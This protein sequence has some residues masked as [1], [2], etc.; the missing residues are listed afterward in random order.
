LCLTITILII[1]LYL[2]K[3]NIFDKI[4]I[5]TILYKFYFKHIINKKIFNNQILFYILY[6]INVLIISFY[7]K[8][9]L[10]IIIL[11]L[12]LNFFFLDIFFIC[13]FVVS[14]LAYYYFFYFSLYYF[15]LQLLITMIINN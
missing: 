6:V 14:L 12:L 5:L 2:I 8:Y 9:E 3:A 13:P 15:Q 1:L 7:L 10:N 4:N 11:Y